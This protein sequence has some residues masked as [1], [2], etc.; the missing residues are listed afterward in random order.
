MRGNRDAVGLLGP[1]IVAR[2]ALATE[3]PTTQP[4]ATPKRTPTPVPVP[5]E[6]TGVQLQLEEV[7]SECDSNP[8]D[9]CAIG[10]YVYTLSWKAPRTKGVEI[11]VYG[12][13]TCFGEDS[14][15]R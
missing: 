7:E 12:V 6:P 15:G 8:A 10:D 2:S 5:P 1:A 9:T 3:S 4:V 13:T 11:R 14:S